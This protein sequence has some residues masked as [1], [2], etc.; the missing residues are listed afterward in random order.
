MDGPMQIGEWFV[1]PSLDSISRGAETRKLE[2]QAV[3]Q[4]RKLCA[5]VLKTQWLPYSTVEWELR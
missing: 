1:T 2:P 3:S 4:L 5:S